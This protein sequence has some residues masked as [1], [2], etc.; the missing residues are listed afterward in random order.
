MQP[1]FEDFLKGMLTKKESK[2]SSA[3][4]VASHQWLKQQPMQSDLAACF[5]SPCGKTVQ[6]NDSPKPITEASHKPPF[7]V[8]TSQPPSGWMNTACALQ[9]HGVVQAAPQMVHPTHF[10]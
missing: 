2:R 4:A 1:D 5:Q 8:P 3:D 10:S 6:F 7:D 9:K